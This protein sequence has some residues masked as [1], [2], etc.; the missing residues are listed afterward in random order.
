MQHYAR[1]LLH[2]DNLEGTNRVKI[3]QAAVRNGANAART[4][5]EKAANGGLDQRGRIHSQFPAFFARFRF[6][7]AQAQA[8]LANRDT[9]WR[10]LFELVHEGK[11]EHYTTFKRH[12]LAIVSSARAT[13]GYGNLVFPRKTEHSQNLV[14]A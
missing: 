8:W 11:I 2:G 7:L 14:D 13:H 5:S 10:N 3:P 6:E 1:L 9:I 4:S 12:T